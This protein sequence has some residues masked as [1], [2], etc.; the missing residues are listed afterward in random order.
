MSFSEPA[1]EPQLNERLNLQL[2]LGLEYA[3]CC[4]GIHWLQKSGL[5]EDIMPKLQ[6]VLLATIIRN[7]SGQRITLYFANINTVAMCLPTAAEQ[8][9]VCD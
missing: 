4:A 3:G 8:Y 9:A 7:S 2:S 5:G 1:E 6:L